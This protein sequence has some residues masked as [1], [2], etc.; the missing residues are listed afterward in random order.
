MGYRSVVGICFI[1]RDEAAPSI[2]EV[3]ALAK[4]KGILQ[5]EGLGKH[6]N[7]ASY[8]WTDDKFLFYVEDVKWYDSYPDVQEMEALYEFVD[9]LNTDENSVQK[10]WYDGAFCRLGEND[11]DI[12]QR[13]FGDD[14]W[15]HMWVN[16]SIGFESDD[17]LGNQSQKI[18]DQTTT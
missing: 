2:P 3:L 10:L 11:D 13:Y 9:A 8:G 14:P 5:G 15:S 7:D 4:T 17:L 1:R 18:T 16:R 6:W 12:E